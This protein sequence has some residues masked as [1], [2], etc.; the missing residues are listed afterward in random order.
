MSSALE[1]ACAELAKLGSAEALS[2]VERAFK[3]HLAQR[4][5]LPASASA[6][7]PAPGDGVGDRDDD[8]GRFAAWSAMLGRRGLSL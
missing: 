7:A 8:R 4:G 5:A 3:A 6:S 2:R 1:S